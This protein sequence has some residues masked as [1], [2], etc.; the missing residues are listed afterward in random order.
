MD[1]T[2]PAAAFTL[3]LTLALAGCGGGSGAD[4]AA[5]LAQQAAAEKANAE[6]LAASS[7]CS[8]T[9]Q[10]G[11]LALATASGS[12]VLPDYRAYSLV[13]PTAEAASAAAARDVALAQRSAD[14]STPTPC[15]QAIVAPGTPAC[16]ANACQLQAATAG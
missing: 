6:A 14:V 10:C 13:S 15:S 3:A 1:E 4:D 7:P 12:C 16:V 9:S 2:I 5:A 11:R 8:A